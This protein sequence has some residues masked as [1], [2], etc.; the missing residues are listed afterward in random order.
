M[1][2]S[3]VV[4]TNKQRFYLL[5]PLA[6]HYARLKGRPV[7]RFRYTVR[8]ASMLNEEELESLYKRYAALTGYFV[9]GAPAFI[10][11]NINPAKGLA[12]GTPAVMHSL[13][14][15][16]PAYAAQIAV[17]IARAEPGEIIDVVLPLSLNLEIPSAQVQ[18]SQWKTA[19]RESLIKPLTVVPIKCDKSSCVRLQNKAYMK[20]NEFSCEA[21]FVITFHKCQ[22]RTMS[23]VVLDLN[24]QLGRGTN[25]TFSSLYVGLSRVRTSA[26]LRL[27]PG[28]NLDRSLF[29]GPASNNHS[30]FSQ[31]DH[32]L[33][34]LMQLKPNADLK[35]WWRGYNLQG[36]WSMAQVKAQWAADTTAN[37]R[38]K[39]GIRARD[40]AARSLGLPTSEQTTGRFNCGAFA[41]AA[42]SAGGES[43]M[44]TAL[45]SDQVPRAAVSARARAATAR[46]RGRSLAHFAANQGSDHETFAGPMQSG[47]AFRQAI[48][49]AHNDPPRRVTMSEILEA[50]RI[51]SNHGAG[52]Q[53]APSQAP[54]REDSGVCSMSI[55][56]NS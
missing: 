47:D 9:Q 7:L 4:P 38:N 13:S 54:V 45:R 20:I 27:F 29:F 25:V 48:A 18:K 17:R 30:A 28:L 46:G 35:S 55:D 1:E 24:K 33:N 5:P 16:N 6:T 10:T 37:E 15:S 36:M 42:P 26:D 53:A 32:P 44:R 21:G 56:S 31:S 14:W 8:H 11:R 49:N 3:I 12:N 2:A 19:G 40:S 23:K 34:Y 39:R 22:G 50:G 52:G 51:A 43:S 41:S